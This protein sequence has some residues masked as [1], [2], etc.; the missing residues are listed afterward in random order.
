MRK[1]VLVLLVLLAFSTASD[2]RSQGNR[3]EEPPTQVLAVPPEPPQAVVAET[4]KLAFFVSPLSSRGLLSQQVRDALRALFSQTGRSQIVKLRAFVA[5]TGDIRRVQAI[6]SETFTARKQAIPAVTVVQVGAL[7]MAG[8]QVVIEATAATRRSENPNGLAFVAGQPVEE[9]GLPSRML[10]LAQRAMP[11]LRSALGSAGL[12]GRDVLLATCFLTS[13]EDV[14]EVRRVVA[15]EF[16]K[17]VMNFIQPERAPSHA[18]AG[19]EVV[20]RLRAPAGAPVKMLKSAAPGGAEPVTAVALV[21]APRVVLAGGQMAFGYEEEDARLA[22]R[23]LAKTLEQERSS[24]SQVA[25]AGLYALSR[26]IGEQAHRIGAGFWGQSGPP[27]STLLPCVGLPSLDA[28]FAI[29]AVAA[30][31]GPQ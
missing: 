7:P 28:S 25:S 1:G 21:G 11:R 24:L 17:A 6:V 12:E 30:V 2:S 14:W 10:T 19:C 23:R 9:S 22:F 18:M 16:P 5:G 26:A 13:M 8:V 4:D 3:Q 31:S 15:A 29:E 27:A 20:A